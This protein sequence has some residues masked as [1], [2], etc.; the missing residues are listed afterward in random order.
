MMP[1]DKVAAGILDIAEDTP[2]TESVPVSAS[3]QVKRGCR[4]AAP[5][6][7]GC[8]QLSKCSASA[9]ARGCQLRST[10]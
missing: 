6:P 5:P 3:L 2:T 4:H 8:S 7:W 10:C 1:A 9:M